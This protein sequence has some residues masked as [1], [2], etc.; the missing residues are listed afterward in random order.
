MFR[1][2]SE[3]HQ[4]LWGTKKN[5]GRLSVCP[6]PSVQDDCR[7]GPGCASTSVLLILPSDRT[8]AGPAT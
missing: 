5:E 7:A 1:L 6:A 4:K 2:C 3:R 8:G